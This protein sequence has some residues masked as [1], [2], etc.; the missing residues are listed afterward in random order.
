MKKLKNLFI[1]LAAGALA[2]AM[3]VPAFAADGPLVALTEEEKAAA[4]LANKFAEFPAYTDTNGDLLF[5]TSEVVKV[6][7]TKYSDVEDETLAETLVFL[8]ELNVIKGFDDGTFR[9]NN[10]ISRAEIALVALRV[11]N[12]TD[13]MRSDVKYFDVDETH[14]LYDAIMTASA[15]G[16]AG[17]YSD[18][19]FRPDQPIRAGELVVMMMRALGYETKAYL[20]GGY[21]MG[22]I[23]LASE[24][25]VKL[26][27]VKS[28]DDYITRGD[29]AKFILDVLESPVSQQ[30]S[31][32]D[33]VSF[34]TNKKNTALV[35]YHDIYTAKGQMVANDV[36][37]INTSKTA[38][39]YAK[40]DKT[41]YKL[42]N[43][44]FKNYLG[45]AIKFYYRASAHDDVGTLVYAKKQVGVKEL[46]IKAK[47]LKSYT[48]G[49]IQYYDDRE[50]TKTATV[51]TAPDVIKNGVHVKNWNKSI[52]DIPNGTVKLV[53]NDG[54]NS[55]GLVFIDT[56]ANVVNSYLGATDTKVQIDP[57]HWLATVTFDAAD[58]DINLELYD[59]TGAQIDFNVSGGTQFNA[60]GIEIKVVNLPPIPTYSVLAIYADKYQDSHGYL[61]PSEDL[62]TIKIKISDKTVTGKIDSMDIDGEGIIIIDGVEYDV[63]ENHFL[64]AQNRTLEIG[65]TAKFLLDIEGNVTDWLEADGGADWQYGFLIKAVVNGT[66][67][68]N[69]EVKYLNSD[70]DVITAKCPAKVNVNGK[71]IDGLKALSELE[72]AAQITGRDISQLIKYKTDADGNITHIQTITANYGIADGYPADQ[73]NRDLIRIEGTGAEAKYITRQ[74]FRAKG[75][76]SY[77]LYYDYYGGDAGASATDTMGVLNKSAYAYAQPKL[78][79]VAPVTESDDEEAYGVL[80]TWENERTKNVEVYDVSMARVPE[81][82]VIYEAVGQRQLGDD[83]FHMYIGTE[84]GIDKDGVPVNYAVFTTGFATKKYA[85]KNAEA[86]GYD[87]DELGKPTK[88]LK[89]GDVVRPRGE[90]DILSG[91]EIIITIDEVKEQWKTNKGVTTFNGTRRDDLSEAYLVEGRW[92]R[93]GRG[94]INPA[95]EAR[96]SDSVF[97]WTTNTAAMSSGGITY[98]EID[99]SEPEIRPA[100]ISDIRPAYKYGFGKASLVY[101]VVGSCDPRFIAVYNFDEDFA[102]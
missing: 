45:Y 49:K 39:N 20:S 24:V 86:L 17:G 7:L 88:F 47:D 43:S 2:L 29:A 68:S 11:M 91:V 36:T 85:I 97:F 32:G 25:G 82:A 51:K 35:H 37:G 79:F 10:Y 30:I 95:T 46:E 94:D 4:E 101:T 80:K 75:T 65:Q 34:D 70:D 57:M 19:N 81:V 56:Y 61:I 78:R 58:P 87:L 66:I 99:R 102:E 52:F 60:D 64:F 28:F 9:P 26:P 74:A 55:Y 33:D 40:I 21:Y 100:I 23:A 41:N 8:N 76:G 54:S 48:T 3:T 93:I 15:L 98:N 42:G 12:C 89:K 22:Y 53:A 38:K 1:K 92:L 50:N 13:S 77:G 18:G 62:T 27:N 72:K 44:A 63:A 31:F 83:L 14:G 69:M 90:D 16:V 59:A 71:L 84:P 96:E 67:G 6:G 5:E 73:L